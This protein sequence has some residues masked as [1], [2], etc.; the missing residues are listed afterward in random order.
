LESCK[1]KKDL[2]KLRKGWDLVIDIDSKDFEISKIAANLIIKALKYHDIKSISCKFSG[3][4]GFHIAVPFDS[5][6][7]TI[8]NEDTKRLFPELPRIIAFYLNK[9][10]LDSA[11][12]E[13]RTKYELYT[14]QKL[15]DFAQKLDLKYEDLIIKKNNNMLDINVSK[16]ISIDTI[17]INS[18]HLCRM[19]YS[20]NE[21][22]GL[23]SIPVDINKVMQ[24]NRE[25]ARPENVV[26]ETNTFLRRN[27]I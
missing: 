14:T 24:F 10:I 15:K 5:F 1:D 20:M 18:R 7:A 11:S 25:S 19:C 21:K 3:N 16:L 8:N 6:P 2:D 26:V 27:N 13:I 9:M 22:S 17:L 4:K 12:N 23:V